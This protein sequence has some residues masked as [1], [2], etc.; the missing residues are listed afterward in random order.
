MGGFELIIMCL[1][2]LS[3]GSIELTIEVGV[4]GVKHILKCLDP[5]S[6]GSIELTSNWAIIMPEAY[7]SRSP[8]NRV[9]RTNIIL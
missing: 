5:L 7:L 4:C 2:P 1:D 8:I 9:N 3:I 6:I